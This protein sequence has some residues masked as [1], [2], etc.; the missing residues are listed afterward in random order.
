[1]PPPDF[2]NVDVPLITPETV[3]FPV[4]AKIAAVVMVIAPEEVAA[5]AL[6]FTKEP[7]TVKSSLVVNPFKST[8]APYAMV[9][10]VVDPKAALLPT[11]MVPAFT[12]VAPL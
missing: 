9:V 7:L 3:T 6:L 8:V 5:E 2:V 4:P 1:M 11:M 10:A 12:F